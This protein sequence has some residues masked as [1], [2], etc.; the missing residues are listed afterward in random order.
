MALLVATAA[1]AEAQEPGSN[2][3][4]RLRLQAQLQTLNADLLSHDSATTVLQALCD[5]HVADAPTI[6]ARRIGTPADP[7]AANAA[8]AELGAAANEPI[9]LRR[10]ELTC[11]EAVL[12]RADNWYLPGRLTAG[13]NAAL[14][15]T[16]TP[17]GVVVRPLAFQRRTLLAR[18][19]FNPLP[20]GWEAKA[21]AGLDEPLDL[22]AEVLQHRAL[23]QT[24]DGRPFSLLV[25]TYTSA[26]LIA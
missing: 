2:Y 3:V 15:R 10:V 17:F 12:S 24:P 16:Q 11:G 5:R 22:P 6:H 21:P 23:L 8:R 1:P 18:L 14:E 9:R 7:A 26:A 25:E 20:C 19:L 4:R 13:M